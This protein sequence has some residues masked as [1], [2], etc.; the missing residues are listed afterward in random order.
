MG[1]SALISGIYRRLWSS[2]GRSI[3]EHLLRLPPESRHSRFGMG[4]SDDFVDRY[5]ERSL[6]VENILFGFI[7]D[8]ELR[9]LGELRPLHPH[10]LFG[11]GGEMEAAFSVEPAWQNNGIGNELLQ[12]VISAARVRCCTT[13]YLSFLTSNRPMR[14]LALKSGAEISGDGSETAGK[15]APDLPDALTV[16]SE[17]FDNARSISIAALD[18]QRRRMAGDFNS[19]SR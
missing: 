2:D 5:A 3:R 4:V 7:L 16:W 12:R 13:L 15:I 18:F 8:G 17:A 11:I 6:A 1:H 14:R 10:R 9:G 19:P